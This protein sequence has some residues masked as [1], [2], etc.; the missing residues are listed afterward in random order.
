ME[1]ANSME[2]A[3]GQ[4]DAWVKKCALLKRKCEEYEEV[5]VLLRERAQSRACMQLAQ[6]IEKYSW[7]LSFSL[8]LISLASQTL[9]QGRGWSGDA[10]SIFLAC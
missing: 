8:G 10:G 6:T 9:T 1:L 7:P 3:G 2:G 5:R 4:G